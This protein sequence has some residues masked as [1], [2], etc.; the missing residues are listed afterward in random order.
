MKKENKNKD[1]EINISYN[2]T[3]DNNN[4][5]DSEDHDDNADSDDSKCCQ[6]HHFMT[7]ILITAYFISIALKIN[8]VT[9]SR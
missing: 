7:V 5:N 6:N 9:V 4:S 3:V 2:S 1:N 8:Y